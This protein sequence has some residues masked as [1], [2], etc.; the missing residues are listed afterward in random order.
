MINEILSEILGFDPE[1][2]QTLETSR[3]HVQVDEGKNLWPRISLK[4]VAL[5]REGHN[6]D[7]RSIFVDEQNLLLVESQFG[8]IHRLYL[9]KFWKPSYPFKIVAEAGFSL[10]AGGLIPL[11]PNG[12][13]YFPREFRAHNIENDNAVTL[14][15]W[16]S[17][18]CSHVYFEGR[19][20]DID[21]DEDGRLRRL[22]FFS[23]EALNQD[24]ARGWGF[25]V[26]HGEMERLIQERVVRTFTDGNDT[27]EVTPEEKVL[28][29]RRHREGTLRDEITIPIRCDGSTVIDR[30]FDPE[31]VKDPAKASAT[32]DYTWRDM[33]PEQL[34]IVMGVSKWLRY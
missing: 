32:A 14:R 26:A 2:G 24:R 17:Q 25:S 4:D 15:L 8:N 16:G 6:V 7:L 21:F 19:S 5:A 22:R 1:T 33:T 30:L 20:G 31:L 28:D 29:I 34:L 10:K 12:E 13:G 27:Y 3:K 18:I 23:T 9:Q 11:D